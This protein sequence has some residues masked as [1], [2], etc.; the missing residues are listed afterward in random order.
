MLDNF[1]QRE[2][3]KAGMKF[4]FS[5]VALPDLRDF[6]PHLPDT[7]DPESYQTEAEMVSNIFFFNVMGQDDASGK[8]TLNNDWLDL[9]WDEEIGETPIFRKIEVLLKSLAESM[10][11]RNV[12]MS[13][14]VAY[15]RG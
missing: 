11:G 15:Y 6:F 13:S 3:L 8:F 7:Y 12:P 5:N 14:P 1:V 10:G 2:I 9:N 4:A